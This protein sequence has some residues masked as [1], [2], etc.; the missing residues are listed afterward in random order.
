MRSFGCGSSKRIAR[1]I[2]TRFS[3]LFTWVNSL[4]AN[5]MVMLNSGRL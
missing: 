1:L 2:I 4:G 5:G 3:A